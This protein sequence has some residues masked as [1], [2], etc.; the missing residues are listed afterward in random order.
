MTEGLGRRAG[1]GGRSGSLGVRSNWS[2]GAPRC[3][4][5]QRAPTR[6]SKRSKR[7]VHTVV[8]DL[9]SPASA[10]AGGTSS[11][12]GSAAMPG[13]AQTGT[14]CWAL[15]G[16]RAGLLAGD[17]GKRVVAGGMVREGGARLPSRPRRQ[18][19]SPSRG[20]SSIATEDYNKGCSQSS[21]RVCSD[22]G[23]K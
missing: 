16:T 18:E 15:A 14:G 10:G 21:H 22:L 5:L 19:R 13:S 7:F 23:I 4:V 6:P 8:C 2:S 1:G 11:D 3:M 20:E 9:M 17:G 12:S